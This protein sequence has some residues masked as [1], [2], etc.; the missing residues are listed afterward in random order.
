MAR[1]K[2][3]PP[4]DEGAPGPGSWIVT[5]SDCMTLLL[6]FF[7][8]LL[9]FSSFDE[10]SLKKL[11][12]IFNFK[13]E[14]KSILIK[15]GGRKESVFKPIDRPTDWSESG[16][17][18][19]VV[20]IKTESV[21]NPRPSVWLKNTDDVYK[22]RRSFY[23]H[24]DRMFWGQGAQ[25]SNSGKQLLDLMAELMKL[26]PCQVTVDHSYSSDDESPNALW[27]AW[28]IVHYF[29]ANKQIP[30]EQ[31]TITN[32]ES[33]AQEPFVKITLLAPEMYQ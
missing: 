31:F 9:V 13:E 26:V 29:E 17:Q 1:N 6:C 18:Q 22:D 8:L 27:R 11:A 24:S 10:V 14:N 2:P 15:E 5:F 12:D 28:S 4:V 25:L 3:T 20:D 7:V 19:Q 16:S 30:P 21:T 23:I 33:V 32:S